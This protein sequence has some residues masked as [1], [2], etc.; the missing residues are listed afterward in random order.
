MSDGSATAGGSPDDRARRE[1]SRFRRARKILFAPFHVLQ[2]L[3]HAHGHVVSRFAKRARACA[4]AVS[5]FGALVS[6]GSLVSLASLASL[7]KTHMGRKRPLQVFSLVSRFVEKNAYR[8]RAGW[9]GRGGAER[10]EGGR[11]RGH[12]DVSGCQGAKV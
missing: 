11:H 10:A 1:K 4:C 8:R 9:K 6:L 5:N 7:Y 3:T 12:H 2:R